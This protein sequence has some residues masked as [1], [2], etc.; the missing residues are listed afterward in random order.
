M[1]A[2]LLHIKSTPL[3]PI[4]HKSAGTLRHPRLILKSSLSETLN[5]RLPTAP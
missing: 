2:N 1:V 4:T 3:W 5:D